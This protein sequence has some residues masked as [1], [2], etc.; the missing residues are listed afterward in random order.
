MTEDANVVAEAIT[1]FNEG[2]SFIELNEDKTMVRRVKPFEELTPEQLED[3]NQRTVHFKGFPQ[4][5]TLDLIKKFC[6]QFGT[7][8]SVEMRRYREDKRFKV[9]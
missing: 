3:L 4:D 7:V 5:V 2:G 8:V 6:S 9:S 1:E